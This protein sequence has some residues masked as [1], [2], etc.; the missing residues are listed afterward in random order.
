MV[1]IDR[2]TTMDM[3]ATLKGKNLTEV[4]ITDIIKNM[5]SIEIGDNVIF[6][7][8]RIEEIRLKS[9]L[10]SYLKNGGC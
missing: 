3:E 6:T 9:Y 10:M 4:E 2:H 1:G 7:F 5:F 8:R